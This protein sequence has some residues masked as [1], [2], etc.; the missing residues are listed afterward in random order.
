MQRRV[1]FCLRTVL[2]RRFQLYREM[3]SITVSVVDSTYALASDLIL[4]LSLAV[5]WTLNRIQ[6]SLTSCCCR[7]KVLL[8]SV[9]YLIKETLVCPAGFQFLRLGREFTAWEILSKYSCDLQSSLDH[10]YLVSFISVT[11]DPNMVVFPQFYP[12]FLLLHSVPIAFFW[13]PFDCC[14][15]QFLLTVIW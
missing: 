15:V 11:H 14:V 6:P 9:F 1:F 2:C 5:G 7:H 4:I 10:L 3:T 12:C 8:T 13:T